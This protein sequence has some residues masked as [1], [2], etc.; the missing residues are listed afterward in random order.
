MDLGKENRTREHLLFQLVA[1][2]PCHATYAIP[3]DE[4]KLL[5]GS[6]LGGIDVVLA[7]IWHR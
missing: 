5:L 7:V 1:K 4:I 6:I 2:Y 3:N